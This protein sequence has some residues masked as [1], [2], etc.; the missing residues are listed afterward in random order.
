MC[1]IQGKF[2][3][4]RR[5]HQQLPQRLPIP[6]GQFPRL[7]NKAQI[8]SALVGESLLA[9]SLHGWPAREGCWAVL[10][11]GPLAASLELWNTLR[12]AF[13][14]EQAVRGGEPPHWTQSVARGVRRSSSRYPLA[15]QAASRSTANGLAVFVAFRLSLCSVLL[16]SIPPPLTR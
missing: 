8:R 3:S 11:A 5:K 14:M 13:S 12:L 1:S 4:T 9:L 2:R 15:S 6:K 10:V 16:V 7:L